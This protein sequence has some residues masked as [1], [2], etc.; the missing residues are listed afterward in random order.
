MKQLRLILPLVPLLALPGLSPAEESGL[1]SLGLGLALAQSPYAGADSSVSLLPLLD[2]QGER[3][4]VRGLSAGVH[5]YEHD[6]F[7]LDAFMSGRFDSID[8]DEFGR[9]KLAANGIDRDLLDNRDDSVDLGLRATWQGP[10]GELQASAKADI[11]SASDG[12]ELTL[13]YGYPFQVAG[14]RV[15]PALALSYLSDRLANYYYGTLQEEEARG[16]ARYRPGAAVVPSV[17]L[18]MS[19]SLGERWRLDGEA[20]YQWLPG[21]LSDSPLSEGD[22]GQLGVRI[23]VSWLFD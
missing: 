4:F 17:S 20:R 3:L 22:T 11:S 13:G 2:Y 6:G 9:A 16:V 5:L 1:R 7:G 10:A 19:R 15:K 14:A 8:R 12:Y 18:S 23:G 21:R